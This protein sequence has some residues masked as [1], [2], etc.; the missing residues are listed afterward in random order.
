MSAVKLSYED[1]SRAR[2]NQLAINIVIPVACQRDNLNAVKVITALE[3]IDHDQLQGH[4][5]EIDVSIDLERRGLET[6]P[7]RLGYRR[8]RYLDAAVT[9]PV[10]RLFIVSD[11]RLNLCFR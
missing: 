9:L 6:R 1:K 3:S 8:L 5:F 4:D 2:I 7:R 10:G 11:S